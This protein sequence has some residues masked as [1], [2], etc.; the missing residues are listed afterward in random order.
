MFATAP[1]VTTCLDAIDEL[2]DVRRSVEGA[3]QI[4]LALE[5]ANLAEKESLDLIARLLGYC[6]LS[7][8]AATLR[9]EASQT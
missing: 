1:T 5:I 6:A 8:E 9:F 2:D 7:L 3:A 4:I